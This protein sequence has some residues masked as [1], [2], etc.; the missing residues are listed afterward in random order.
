MKTFHSMLDE[1]Q[2]DGIIKLPTTDNMVEILLNKSFLE[3]IKNEKFN[4]LEIRAGAVDIPLR[5]P[6]QLP[7]GIVTSRPS[8]IFEM[9]IACNG[10]TVNG[11]GEGATLPQPLFTDDSGQTITQALAE[12]GDLIIQKD[13]SLADAVR[14]IADHEFS[15]RKRFPTARMTVEMAIFD[16]VAKAYGLSVSEILG[17]PN[18]NLEVPFG[19][20]IGGGNKEKTL[21]EAETAIQDG[22]RKIKLK[23]TPQSVQTV[24]GVIQELQH[25]H[26]D[27]EIM[28]D[29]NGT[30]D[31]TQDNDCEGIRKLDQLGLVVI[32]EPVSRVGKIRGIEAVSFLRRRMPNFKTKL[33]LDDC[34][35]DLTTTERAISEGL[36]DVI[37]IKPGR[38][39]SILTAIDLA[40]KCK[41]L[42]K[43]IMVGGMLEAT[44]G[45]CMTTTLAALFYSLGFTIPGD[46]S[47]AQERL[48]ADLV[49]D[50]KQLQIGPKGGILL[51][52]GLGWG[53]GDSFGKGNIYEN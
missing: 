6:M 28:V 53:F 37:N 30:F 17:I 39:G 29:A 12:L 42:R 1:S 5:D 44:P 50:S 14:L 7:F 16:A 38:I 51:P 45:R 48:S 24:I 8:G 19:K 10:K 35:V 31:P 27:L 25:H 11:F 4:S 18:S 40:K 21:F 41:A 52:R 26:D 43:Q 15:D 47:L 3:I 36:A 32:E 46:L 20:S 13:L 49:P 2:T 9:T 23:V 22:A 33:C 34:L